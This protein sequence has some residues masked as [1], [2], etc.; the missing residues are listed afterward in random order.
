MHPARIIY[1]SL[2]T[3]YDIVYNVHHISITIQID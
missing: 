1:Q 3:I 2:T